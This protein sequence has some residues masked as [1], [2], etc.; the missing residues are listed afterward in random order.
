MY[1]CFSFWYLFIK[2]HFF[3]VMYGA[4]EEKYFWQNQKKKMFSKYIYTSIYICLC[5]YEGNAGQSG[6]KGYVGEFVSY[7]TV[8]GYVL[9][10]DQ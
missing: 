6:E 8:S 10:K 5:I 3:L 7:N 9:P 4:E 1:F 2:E